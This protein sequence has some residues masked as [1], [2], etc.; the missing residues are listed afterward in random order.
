MLAQGRMAAGNGRC[1]RGRCPLLEKQV[2]ASKPE[3]EAAA[4]VQRL[5]AD[6][7]VAMPHWTPARA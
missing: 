1:A 2:D 3:E 4:D 5:F 6:C 7:I